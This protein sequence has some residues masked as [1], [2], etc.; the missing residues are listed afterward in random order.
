LKDP[1]GRV[2][3]AAVLTLGKTGDERALPSLVWVQQNDPG[4]SGANKIKDHA[5]YAI[6]RIQER[7]QNS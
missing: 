3:S 2:R 6:Q 7:H 1:D 5:T 4:Y